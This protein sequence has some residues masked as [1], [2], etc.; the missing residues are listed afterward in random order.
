MQLCKQKSKFGPFL[1]GVDNV[2]AGLTEYP[3]GGFKR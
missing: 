1:P 2:T 3:D